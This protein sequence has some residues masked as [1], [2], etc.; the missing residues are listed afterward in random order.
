MHF[1]FGLV[2]IC[3]TALRSPGQPGSHKA[4]LEKVRSAGKREL[5]AALRALDD[6]LRA[7]PKDAVAAVER[8][9]LIGGSENPE[10]EPIDPQGPTF[11]DCLDRLERDF[12]DSGPALVYRMDGRYGAEAIAFGEKVLANPRVQL[13]AAEHGHLYERLAQA[14]R[15]VGHA[16]AAARRA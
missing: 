2:L 11:T 13:S 10:D 16:Q 4:S 6:H 3:S 8:C 1:L 15:N 9:R 12:P 5:R 14:E 7:H